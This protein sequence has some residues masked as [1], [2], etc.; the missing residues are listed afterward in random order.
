[1]DIKSLFFLSATTVLF[2]DFLKLVPRL[3]YPSSFDRRH[4]SGHSELFRHLVG[5]LGMKLLH[6]RTEL[7]VVEIVIRW[8][9]GLENL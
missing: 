3:R 4:D 1:M 6:C 7:S 5:Y 8:F 2:D 9:W